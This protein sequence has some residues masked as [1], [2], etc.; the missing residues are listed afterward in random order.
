M[1][2]LANLR[3]PAS[4]PPCP[5][6]I[7]GYMRK[8]AGPSAKDL[9]T[10]E[11]VKKFLASTEHGVIGRLISLSLPLSLSL[12]LFLSPPHSFSLS[13]SLFSHTQTLHTFTHAHSHMLMFTKWAHTL[14][15]Q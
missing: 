11:S 14:A 8:Q 10:L 7:V 5:D 2:M 12:S 4:L 1:F 3:F 6:G 15:S 13:H 9:Q